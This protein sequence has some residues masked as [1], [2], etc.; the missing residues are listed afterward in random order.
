[1]EAKRKFSVVKVPG[2]R[3]GGGAEQLASRLR[4]SGLSLKETRE[5]FESAFGAAQ[6]VGDADTARIL[7]ESGVDYAQGYHAGPP[8]PLTEGNSPL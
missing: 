2:L 1:M 6:F 4:N 3:R 8:Q 5:R 7:R